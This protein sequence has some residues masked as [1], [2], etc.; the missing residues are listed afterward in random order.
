MTWHTL[1]LTED[2]PTRPG[3]TSRYYATIDVVMSGT[4]W[5]WRQ[6]DGNSQYVGPASA[7]FPTEDQAMQDAL[8]SLNGDDWE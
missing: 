7:A 3:F 5:I 6:V 8:T 4:D 1:V 2:H